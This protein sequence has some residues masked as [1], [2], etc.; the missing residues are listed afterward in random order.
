MGGE[1]EEQREE[2]GHLLA[3]GAPCGLGAAGEEGG[4]AE[5]GW[6]RRFLASR[7]AGSPSLGQGAPTSAGPGALV[8]K[9]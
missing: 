1:A 3:R 5:P 6:F 4:D 8:I 9:L 2:E 7:G